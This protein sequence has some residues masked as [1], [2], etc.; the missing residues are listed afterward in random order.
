MPPPN[1][2]ISEIAATTLRSRR[3]QIADNILKNNAGL[4]KLK[5]RGN[6]RYITGG[7]TV[8]EEIAYQENGNAAWYS[9]ADSL[10]V[11]AR[12]MFT[13]ADF[14]PPKQL[15]VPFTVTGLE[16]LQNS[17][18]E[19]KIDLA[20]QRAKASETTLLNLAAEAFYSDGTGYAGK[21]LPG[22]GAFIT[23]SP[24][25]G[26]VGGI[27]RATNSWWRNAATGSLGSVTAA[28]VQG[29]LNTAFN[30]VVRGNDAVD[31]ILFGTTIYST[32][33]ASLQ[34]L[35]RF[36]DPKMAELGFQNLKYKGATVVL[37]G[38]IGGNCPANVG[39]GINTKYLHWRPHKDR[40]VV[41]LGSERTPV[42]QD[43]TTKILAWAGLM[44][45]SGGRF[46]F[47]FQAS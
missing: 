36:T 27:D 24:A 17:G 1:P 30:S 3:G 5:E 20:A 21:Q 37:D 31:L 41:V 39:F 32:F 47:Y 9:G 23:A 15:A 29:Y 10:D 28:N 43:V 16:E 26:T 46:H 44:T 12:E 2:S 13:A 6:V 34:P 42:N 19:Q 45:M 22:L 14:G 35:Q 8:L 7:S 38:G 4:A 33:E 11:S 18:K 40:D 25:T